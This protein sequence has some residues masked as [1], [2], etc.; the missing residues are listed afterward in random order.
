MS[1]VLLSNGSYGCVYHP[2]FSCEGRVLKSTRIVTKVQHNNLSVIQTELTI[3]K[4][5]KQIPKYRHFFVPILKSCNLNFA[6]MGKGGLKECTILK[7]RSN[8][9]LM[10]L[11]YIKSVPLNLYI[12]K[13]ANSRPSSKYNSI[14]CFRQVINSYSHILSALKLLY[15]KEIVHF[16]LHNNNIIYDLKLNIPLIIDFG[17]SMKKSNIYKEFMKNALLFSAKMSQY[18]IEVHLI[19]PIVNR[20]LTPEIIKHKCTQYINNIQNISIIDEY[21]TNFKND[22]IESCVEYYSEFLTLTKEEAIAKIVKYWH[23]WDNYA[24]GLIILKSLNQMI[25]KNIINI[26]SKTITELYR[27]IVKTIAPNPRSRISV[28]EV[29]RLVEKIRSTNDAQF[30]VLFFG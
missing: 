1:N 4:L 20:T 5:I 3:S 19:E 18:A 13:L 27:I 10:Y 2:G 12:L 11:E 9:V 22:Y 16:D 15:E 30:G 17:I 23:T 7:G 21:F 25:Q 14:Y 29:Q 28:G 6:K 24:V 26:K 8:L